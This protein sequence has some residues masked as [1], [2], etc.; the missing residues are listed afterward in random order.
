MW[1]GDGPE[2]W[3]NDWGFTTT[4]PF[5]AFLGGLRH[6][7]KGG[8]LQKGGDGL[9]GPRGGQ[10]THR[11][12]GGGGTGN[13]DSRPE[14]KKTEGVDHVSCERGLPG[15]GAAPAEVRITRLLPEVGRRKRNGG[16]LANWA[17]GQ[18]KTSNLTSVVRLW[19][20]GAGDRSL[21]LVA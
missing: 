20:D 10:P 1:G 14:K 15:G 6:G 4:K 12:W 19:G 9:W 11:G 16:P 7:Y 13:F 8:G 18:D 5:P 21:I 3:E 17:D 2:R